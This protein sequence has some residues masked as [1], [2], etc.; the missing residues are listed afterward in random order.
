MN[1]QPKNKRPLTPNQMG[2]VLFEIG[3]GAKQIAA[4]S[5]AMRHTGEDETLFEALQGAIGS[6][7]QRIG[8]I[9]DIAAQRQLEFTGL[10][11]IMESMEEW[12]LPVGFHLDDLASESTGASDAP[13]GRGR[14]N[15]SN[16]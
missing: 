15:K 10:G 7:A 14:G 2:L 11:P 8:L 1:Q 6:L 12:V 16:P 4:L 13:P 3:E 5:V 9:A